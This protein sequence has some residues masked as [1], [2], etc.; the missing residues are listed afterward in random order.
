MPESN[1]LSFHNCSLYANLNPLKNP[2]KF[3]SPVPEEN[4]E[5]SNPRTKCYLPRL[6][7]ALAIASSAIF[8]LS[9]LADQASSTSISLTGQ[10]AG[11]TPFIVKLTLNVSNI[12]ALQTVGFTI[13]PMAGSVTRPISVTFPI[14]Y[15]Q[16]RGFVALSTN[17]I[18]VP[19]FGLY[20]GY[21]NNVTL[22]FLFND[23]SS[24]HQNFQIPTVAFSSQCGFTVPTVLQA[25]TQDT[26]LSYD[27]IFVKSSCSTK[28]CPMIIDTDGAVRWIGTAAESYSST[29]F[30]NAIYITNGSAKILRQ[31]LDGAYTTLSAVNYNTS[32]GV[33]NFNHNIDSGRDGII[34]DSTTSTLIKCFNVEVDKS[35]N[36]LK[37]WNLASIISNAMTAGGDDPTQFI[38]APP[39]D[40]FHNNGVT[41]RKSDNSLIVSSREDFVIALDYDSGAIKWI[42][43]D[44]TKKWYQFPSLRKYAVTMAPGSVP[45]IGQHSPSITNDNNL[46][47]FDNGQPSDNL[48]PRGASSYAAPRKYQL[49]LQANVA[50]EIWNY[51]RFPAVSSPYCGSA[52]EDAP[53]NYLVDYAT[54][55][56][57][58]QQA[59]AQAEILG[60]NASGNKIFHY[61]YPTTGCNTAFNSIP[62]HL[63]SLVFSAPSATPTPTP[64]PSA[65]ATATPAPTPTPTSMPT[66]SPTPTPTPIVII[67]PTGPMGPTGPTGATGATGAAGANGINGATGATGPTGPTLDGDLGNENVAVGSEALSNLMTGTDN[68]A[69]GFAALLNNTVGSHN[70]AAGS[71]ALYSNVGGPPG[72]GIDNTAAGY[73]ALFSNSTGSGNAAVGTEALFSNTSGSGNTALGNLAGEYLTTGD[74]NIDINHPGVAGDSNTIRI[75]NGATATFI[76]GIYGTAPS[77]A[78][79]TTPVYVDANGNLGTVASAERFKEAI[80]PMDQTSEIILAL[81]PVT[82]RYKNDNDGIPQ[83]GLIAEEVAKLNPNLV[84][85]DKNGHVYTVRYEAVNAMLLNEFLKEH[86]RVEELKAKIAQQEKDFGTRLKEQDAKIQLMNDKMK[87]KMA[88]PPPAM[89][90]SP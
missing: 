74:N 34:L 47:V 27:Y 88:A 41:Y 62:I 86:R 56:G 17:R 90:G 35:G 42:L 58:T 30:D 4:D 60:L 7:V 13:A 80:T 18:T 66:S 8:P 21:T 24:Q 72:A 68:A 59:P 25:R 76:S 65:T 9:L 3:G 78:G 52:Y 83:F 5:M 46:L 10:Q 51:L 71:Q 11:A 87:L 15:L 37:T 43:G 61:Q 19:V 40:W 38:L 6:H 55:G 16:G 39:G 64:T 50:T 44:P 2:Q 33:V 23:G 85:R 28:G 53:L 20:A 14:S 29:F 57:T 22:T 63:E 48:S 77:D 82:F 32:L 89:E 12:S 26:S 81:Q 84:V 31:E 70:T 45:P 67:G 49:D 36:V 75:G 79:T 1:N 69:F 54:V 73:Q